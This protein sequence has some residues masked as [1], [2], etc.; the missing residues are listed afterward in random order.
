M[1]KKEKKKVFICFKLNLDGKLEKS[2]SKEVVKEEK[3]YEISKVLPRLSK[4]RVKAVIRRIEDKGVPSEISPKE[5]SV[6]DL[7]EGNLLKQPAAK[8]LIKHWKKGLFFVI[9]LTHTIQLSIL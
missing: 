4:E 6:E 7:M 3:D 2:N 8:N 5:L 9:L 1:A